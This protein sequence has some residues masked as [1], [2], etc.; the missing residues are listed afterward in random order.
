MGVGVVVAEHRDAL[1]RLLRLHLSK[2][3]IEGFGNWR[4]LFV[5]QIRVTPLAARE[6]I[7]LAHVCE[8]IVVVPVQ[9][10]LVDD[11]VLEG[12]SAALNDARPVAIRPLVVH[13]RPDFHRRV[14]QR[15][16]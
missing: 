4:N 8:V 10:H 3:V 16:H 6:V 9:P 5:K 15:L 14:V 11:V 12:A 2:Q 7:D 13:R 1:I